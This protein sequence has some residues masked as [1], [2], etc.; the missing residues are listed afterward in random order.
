MTELRGDVRGLAVRTGA[1][2]GGA[3]VGLLAVVTAGVLARGGGSSDLAVIGGTL[4]A[5]LLVVLPLG[6][7]RAAQLQRRVG[8]TTYRV[9]PDGALET[10]QHGA[11]LHRFER[12]SVAGGEVAG[13]LGWGGL[14]ARP[15][16][17]R[18]LPRAR[19]WL[20][21][22]TTVSLPPMAL[23]GSAGHDRL[24]T[25]LRSAGVP[26]ESRRDPVATLAWW[27]WAALAVIAVVGI[28]LAPLAFSRLAHVS[29]RAR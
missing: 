15:W 8:T 16:S 9:R 25:A 4:A 19:V 27:R 23:W 2:L 26:V 3:L 21:D 29:L 6:V 11:R 14:L 28:G 20:T 13:V 17:T 22:G 12:G 18:D 10:W 24:A 7:V 5:V 1:A